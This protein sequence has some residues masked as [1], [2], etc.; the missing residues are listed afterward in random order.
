[1]TEASP[2]LLI[3]SLNHE[4]RGVAHRDGKAIFVDGALTGETVTYSVYRK[5]DAF[6]MAQVTRIVRKSHARV[7][8]RCPHFGVCGGCSLQHLEPSAQIAAKQRVLEDNLAHIGKVKPEAMLSA[9]HGPAWGYRSRARLSVKLVEKKGGVL[10]GFHERKSSFVAE[11]D[12]CEVLP[13]RISALIPPLRMLI[14]QLTIRDKLPQI[15]VAATDAVDVLVIR[16][17]APLAEVDEVLLREF[18]DAHHIQWWLQSKGPDTIIPFY[19]LDAP[20]LAYTL[21]E[22]K[23]VMPFRPSEF[24]QVNTAVNPI[25]M[26][27]A[28]QLL[29]PQPFERIVDMFCGLG[30][31]TLPIARRAQQVVGIE[32]SKEL[33]ARACQNAERNGLINTEF[34][35]ENLFT[36]TPERMAALG[37]FDKMLIDPPRDGAYALVQSLGLDA[38]KRIVYVSCNPAT[39]A[40]DA[41]VLVHE[42]GYRLRA[43]GIANMFPHTAHVESIALFERA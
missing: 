23:L 15:E 11:M 40:R 20:E 29:D 22:F 33:V 42:K 6:E 34:M 3:E 18:A 5:K 16:H 17:M 10:V 28:M 30:N 41:A 38:P 36:I 32:G 4:G 7:K 1:M 26:R 8:P 25:L 2:T 35:V 9:I 24:T 39:L 31:F 43:A 14:M 21:P 27:R 37:H 19:P 12:S 13:A